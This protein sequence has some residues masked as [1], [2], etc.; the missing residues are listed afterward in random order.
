M[1]NIYHANAY[2]SN[3]WP[4]P[5]QQLEALFDIFTTLQMHMPQSLSRDLN[6][7]EWF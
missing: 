1:N 3:N 5:N 4:S 6:I 2:Y 7:F